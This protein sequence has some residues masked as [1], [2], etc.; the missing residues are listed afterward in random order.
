[1]SSLLKRS[2]GR[3]AVASAVSVMVIDSGVLLMMSSA[4]A[5]QD[6]LAGLTTGVNDLF[7]LGQAGGQ[8]PA[9]APVVH[10]AEPPL[11]AAPRTQCGPGS[12]P[13]P[14]IP[15]RV[16]AGSADRGLSCNVTQISHQGSS[17]QSIA[18]IYINGRRVTSRHGHDLRRVDLGHLPAGTYTVVVKART[19]RRITI[20]ST[21][22]YRGCTQTKRRQRVHTKRHRRHRR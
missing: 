18:T 19:S 2:R 12:R 4:G 5:A 16:P 14:G 20:T 7:A 10:R 11:A 8:M 9:T 1:M 22:R 13:E 15:G 6:P 3:A 21:R 17:G